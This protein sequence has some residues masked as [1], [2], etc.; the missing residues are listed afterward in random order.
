ADG[1]LAE[2]PSA[3]ALTRAA[4]AIERASTLLGT[5]GNPRQRAY[6]AAATARLAWRRG[7]RETAVAG[8]QRALAILAEAEGGLPA[9]RA[10]I[11]RWTAGWTAR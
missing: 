9:D 1:W 10:R 3:E 5:S 6:L 2:P 11:E 4:D 8:A 7:E